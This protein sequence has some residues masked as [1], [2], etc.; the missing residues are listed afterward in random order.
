M[1]R[2]Q[3]CEG[4]GTI[5]KGFLW[6]SATSCPDCGG[7]GEEQSFADLSGTAALPEKNPLFA[8]PLMD[9][10]DCKERNEENSAEDEDLTPLDLYKETEEQ[11]MRNPELVKQ[12]CG[13]CG[14]QFASDEDARKHHHVVNKISDTPLTFLL[15]LPPGCK[16]GTSEPAKIFAKA[17]AEL[18]EKHPDAKFQ[19]L[20]YGS[21]FVAEQVRTN[22]GGNLTL[23]Y[24][25]L[26][27]VLAVAL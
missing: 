15:L 6:R 26:E 14:Q 13:E 17:L 20:P 22:E 12:T 16:M 8:Q 3:K 23:N 24:Q 27:S 9:N 11:T 5:R 18:K 7:S 4:K 19:L 25:Y 2:C 1:N 10:A 21:F